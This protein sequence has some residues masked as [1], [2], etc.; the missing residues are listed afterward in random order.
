MA[1]LYISEFQR[2]GDDDRSV[3][4]IAECPPLAQQAI[5]ISAVS[6]QSAAFNTLTRFIRVHTDTACWL[7]WG[8]SPTATTS[9]MPFPADATEYFGVI[10]G[11]KVA[12]ITL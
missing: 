3:A 8:A 6:A 12:G 10:P 2:M 1:T 9:K 7:E 4:Q 5:T 11:Q